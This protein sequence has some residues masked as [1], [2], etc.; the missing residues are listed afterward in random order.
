MVQ[1]NPNARDERIIQRAE[2]TSFLI[3]RSNE[4]DPIVD[5]QK[6]EWSFFGFFFFRFFFFSCHKFSTQLFFN[7]QKEVLSFSKKQKKSKMKKKI[8]Q[9]PSDLFNFSQTF[10]EFSLFSSNILPKSRLSQLYPFLSKWHYYEWIQ[11]LGSM[12]F[13][14]QSVFFFV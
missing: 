8:S 4:I 6:K 2:T 13:F 7:S 10:I 5:F 11:W 12:F 1:T 14:L 9:R 3:N